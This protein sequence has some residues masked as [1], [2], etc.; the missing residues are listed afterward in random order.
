M[1]NYDH[2]IRLSFPY[3]LS[4]LLLCEPGQSQSQECDIRSRVLP[5]GGMHYYIEAVSFFTNG[6]Q[7]LAGGIITDGETFY[8]RL[9]PVPILTREQAKRVKGNLT[10]ALANDTTYE[11]KF[12][13]AHFIGDTVFSVIYSISKEHL[14]PL[15]KHRIR[16]AVIDL[17]EERPRIYHFGNHS[18]QIMV[19]LKCFIEARKKKLFS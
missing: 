3:I 13:D 5:S 9:N 6:S 18:E 4:L 10:L 17:N 11:L 7:H 16:N 15:I 1:M 2:M 14:D 8:I 12:F 19:Q